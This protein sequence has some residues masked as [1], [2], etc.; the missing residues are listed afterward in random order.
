MN[1]RVCYITGT[2]ADYGLMS[3]TLR[4]AISRGIDVQVCATGMHLLKT[5]GETIQDIEADEIPVAA[6]I[7]VNLD[8]S[9]GSNMAYALADEL[10]GLTTAL[11][12]IKPDLVTVLGDRGEMLAGALAALHLNIPILHIHGGELSGTVDEPVRHAISK[13]SNFHAVTTAAARQRLIRMGEHEQLIR[14]TGAPGLDDIYTLPRTPREELLSASGF[15]VNRP[16]SLV[17][18]HPVVQDAEKAGEQI[19]VIL[20]CLT[21]A[22]LQALILAPNSDAGGI[23]IQARL[24]NFGAREGTKIV[25]HLPRADYISWLAAADVMIGNSSSGIIEAASVGTC[26]VNVGNRQNCR[27]RNTNVYDCRVDRKEINTTIDL[28]LSASPYTGGNCYGSGGTAAK[29]VDWMQTL[30]LDPGCLHQC[31][32]Y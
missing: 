28:A 30:S 19:G 6:C 10:T 4:L 25:T 5:Y 15:D 12:D 1:R 29:L 17:V 21:D 32:A 27:E 23:H 9:H 7:P 26:V 13:L 31:N 11:M 18:F 8:G 3:S 24:H 16:V 2:R 22:D 20:Q 14:V